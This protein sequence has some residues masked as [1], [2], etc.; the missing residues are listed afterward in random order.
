M[1]KDFF[2]YHPLKLRAV[3]AFAVVGCVA[4]LAWSLSSAVRTGEPQEVARAGLCLGLLLAMAYVLT[5]LAPREGWGV[6]LSPTA[7]TVS[8]PIEGV[9]EI[10]WSTLK[11]VQR[12]GKRHDT[13]MLFV[14]DHRRILVPRHLFA[15]TADFEQ[16]VAAI[17]ERMP[18]PQHDA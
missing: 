7:L 4:L 10:P 15:R 14:G 12:S 16:L 18:P 8:K 5:R 1:T 6:K 11:E 13:L 2:P 9:M 17:E 3:L